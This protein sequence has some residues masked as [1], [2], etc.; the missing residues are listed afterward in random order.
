MTLDR[1]T[2]ELR[3]ADNARRELRREREARYCPPSEP[4]PA[5]LI[6]MIVAG[7]RCGTFAAELLDTRNYYLKR[8]K[9][10]SYFRDPEQIRALYKQAADALGP[11]IAEAVKAK[12]VHLAAEKA[13]R[14]RA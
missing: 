7:G 10:E 14:E 1:Y 8:A 9:G 4:E 6:D 13:V 5:D 11:V 12:E 2:Y 3:E